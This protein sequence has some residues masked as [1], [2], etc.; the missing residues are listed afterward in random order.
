MVA[1][2][3]KANRNWLVLPGS[4]LL[5]SRS[6]SLHHRMDQPQL[7]GHRAQPRQQIRASS[8]SSNGLKSRQPAGWV[9][10]GSV[11]AHSPIVALATAMRK[12]FAERRSIV[13]SQLDFRDRQSHVLQLPV[14]G[15]PKRRELD[16]D[17]SMRIRPI[18]G[19]GADRTVLSKNVKR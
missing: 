12:G 9:G 7:R 16:P 4:M 1:R 3:A 8:L 10:I 17:V 13:V 18:G 5:E 19:N 15:R 2:G 6:P 14:A 11:G